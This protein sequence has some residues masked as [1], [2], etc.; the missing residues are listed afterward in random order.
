[1]KQVT[2]ASPFA[3]FADV[4]GNLP[5]LEAILGD[6]DRRG[7]TSLVC[8]GDLVGYGP[9]PNEVADLMRERRIPTVMGNYDQGIG[10]ATGDCGC[11]YV[12]DEQRAEGA[13]SLAWTDEVASAE[14]RAYLRSL[15][16][17]L[18]L[19]TPA[20][21]LLAVH[22]SPRR[23][24]EYLFEDRPESAMSRMAAQNP[25]RAILFGHTHV[26]YARE[27]AG[28]VFI[29]VGSGGRP[30]DADWRVCYALVDASPAS[31]IDV[32]FVRLA[33]DFD[34]LQRAL[35][36]TPLITRFAGPGK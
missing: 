10:F 22:G 27:V 2:M 21:E 9:F 1:L 15:E 28:T 7:I 12:T 36:E 26:P 17:R 24:N 14:T 23:I 13:V 19:A 16:D 31:R 34:R 33:Y 5:A 29:N 11:L 30:K 3:V 18:V 25:Y 32:E 8:L 6:I 35:A 4:H 20:G